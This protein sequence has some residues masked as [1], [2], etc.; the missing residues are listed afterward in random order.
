MS[1][2][3]EILN[4]WTNVI[5]EKPEVEKMAMDRAIV[6]STCDKNVNNICNSCG[7]PLI[8]KTRSE[9][10]TCPEGKWIK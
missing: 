1:K 10:S 8:A 5:W 7:C 4:G 9:Y 3:K 6:C 2:L